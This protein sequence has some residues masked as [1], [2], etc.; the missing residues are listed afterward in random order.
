MP[1]KPNERE[2]RNLS[3]FAAIDP[4]EANKAPDALIL[5]GVPVVF[6]TP[7]VICTIDGVEYKEQ[8]DAAALD[9]CDMSDFILNRNH[10]M[11]D[12]T[13]YARSKNGSLTWR[14]TETGLAIE[15]RL[16]GE[17]ERHR[18]LYRDILAGRVDKMSFSFVVGED[19]YDR[20]SRT[21]TIRR[22]KKIYDVSAVDFPAYN[23]TSILAARDFFSLEHERERE[24]LEQRRRRQMLLAK[25]LL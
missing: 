20:D 12:G 5:R 1:Y 4:V 15:A 22:I 6:G 24:A 17:D 25:T 14:V 2:Y 16:D 7:T 3:N 19:S 8:I 13:V 21:R 11:N 23:D 10:G 18:A 9:G